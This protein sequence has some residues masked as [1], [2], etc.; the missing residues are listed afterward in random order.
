[1]QFKGTS[2]S[3]ANQP[4]VILQQVEDSQLSICNGYADIQYLVAAHVSI[5]YS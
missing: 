2:Y 3:L 5:V 1:M 4:A